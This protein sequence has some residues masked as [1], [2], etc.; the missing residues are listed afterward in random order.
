[1]S[2][3][4]LT[5]QQRPAAHAASH[6]FSTT[7]ACSLRVPSL[8]SRSRWAPPCPAA[9][10]SRT[11]CVR[12]VPRLA[13]THDA[14]AGDAQFKVPEEHAI[15][16]QTPEPDMHVC[17]RHHMTAFSRSLSHHA[18]CAHLTRWTKA[19]RLRRRQR[20]RGAVQAWQSRAPALRC[21][22]GSWS[23]GPAPSSPR[24]IS[25]QQGTPA[26]RRSP[27]SP[28][29]DGSPRRTHGSG[30]CGRW[31]SP[32]R[33]TEARRRRVTS[34]HGPVTHPPGPLSHGN[35]F[36]TGR[37]GLVVRRKKSAPPCQ[38]AT[39]CEYRQ[40]CLYNKCPRA[41]SVLCSA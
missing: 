26:S 39:A 17:G 4:D 18:G 2:Q 20:L 13:N 11:N 35:G 24:L 25:A 36:T 22:C 5:R 9:R 37:G 30:P 16:K 19:R 28:A 40:P 10:T 15:S 8:T 34:T 31:S 7:V 1:M 27:G 29:T 23:R 41:S 3:S 12:A 6:R 32:C 21:A 38:A 14:K 33:S